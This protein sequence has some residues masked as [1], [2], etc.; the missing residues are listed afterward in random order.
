M[1][2]IRVEESY[3]CAM[4]IQ[5][6]ALHDTCPGEQVTSRWVSEGSLHV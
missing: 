3:N 2:G 6:V 1:D 5:I 4:G